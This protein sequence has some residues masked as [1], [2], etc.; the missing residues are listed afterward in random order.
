KVSAGAGFLVAL[1]CA[2]LPL[3]FL[4]PFPSLSPLSLSSSFPLPFLF[5]FSPLLSPLPPFLFPPP[6]SS[7]PPSFSFFSPPPFFLSPSS[8]S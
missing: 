5:S 8:F 3:P 1:P 4:P 6:S 2:I 7:P